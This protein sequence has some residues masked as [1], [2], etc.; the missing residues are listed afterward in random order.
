MR[1]LILLIC[2]CFFIAISIAQQIDT[3]YVYQITPATV[4][5]KQF[6]SREEMAAVLMIPVDIVERMSTKALVTTCMNFPMFK[7]LYFFNDIQTGFTTLKSSFN[8]FQELLKRED[9]GFE[10]LAVYKQMH[11]EEYDKAGDDILK[12][13]F[14][15]KFVQ[16][17][18]FI[19]QEEIV[20]TLSENLE[21]ELLTEAALKYDSKKK[22]GIFSGFSLSPSVLIIGRIL[23]K[24]NQLQELKSQIA[25]N[26]V[27]RFLISGT[28]D[29]MEILEQIRALK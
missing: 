5:W 8:G 19:A 23:N 14:T 10:L 13:D 26:A 28:A 2:F 25:E 12:S 29:R 7:D 15:F 11:P 6:Q 24:N 4:D 18:M 17:E 22:A 27:G 3:P 20:N 1:K 21:R 16:I 9:A